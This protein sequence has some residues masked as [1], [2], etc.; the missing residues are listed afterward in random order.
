M[1]LYFA[2]TPRDLP[3]VNKQ[4]RQGSRVWTFVNVRGTD[5]SGYGEKVISWTGGPWTPLDQ[6]GTAGTGNWYRRRV[7][8][9]NSAWSLKR[10]TGVVG[11]LL[12]HSVISSKRKNPCDLIDR[13]AELTYVWVSFW[14]TLGFVF[15][16]DPWPQSHG[17]PRELRSF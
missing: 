4:F 9:L 7:P 12:G 8:S 14:K 13:R 15:F 6:P 11:W 3:H 16:W 1:A 5:R 10:R 17:G 2:Q